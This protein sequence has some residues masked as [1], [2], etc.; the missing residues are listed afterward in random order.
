M[1]R[2]TDRSTDPTIKLLIDKEAELVRDLNAVRRVLK[3]LG[4]NSGEEVLPTR[5]ETS[6][7]GSIYSTGKSSLST[8]DQIISL[9]KDVLKRA[10]RLPELQ[11]TYEER[12]K[13]NARNL[14]FDVIKLR[15]EGILMSIKFNGNWNLQY[16]G[17]AEWVLIKE[18]GPEFE[19]RYFH[20]D[21]DKF[22]DG[23]FKSELIVS[24]TDKGD[25]EQ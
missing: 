3:L 23:I 7:F 17:L 19:S 25:E 1:E 10:V 9:F 18:E 6:I 14:R 5:S 4:Q 12:Y 24:D 16:T 20:A 11:R 15:R 8:K 22:P 2:E 13:R 21:P